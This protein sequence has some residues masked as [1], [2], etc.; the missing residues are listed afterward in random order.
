MRSNLSTYQLV[1]DFGSVSGRIKKL[2]IIW[3]H[4]P[5]GYQEKLEQKQDKRDSRQSK[6]EDVPMR[7]VTSA[8]L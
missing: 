4:L 1:Y 6:N 7:N 8:L 2:Y 5:D 3:A